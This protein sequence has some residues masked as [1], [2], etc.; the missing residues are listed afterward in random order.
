MNH[1]EHCAYQRGFSHVAGIDEAGRGP[2]AGPVVAAAVILPW[3]YSNEEIRDSKKLSEVKRAHLYQ[4]I[5][6][7]ALDVGIGV[8]EPAEIDRINILQA[9]ILAMKE[10]V[11]A[12]KLRADYLLID[13]RN[14]LPLPLEQQPIVKG[15]SLSISIAAASIIAKVS[16]DLIMDMYHRQY[17]QYN[18]QKNKGYPTAEHVEAL[19]RH[20]RCKIHRRSF[21]VR[22]A[23]LIACDLF[24]DEEA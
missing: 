24:T 13:G 7:D 2:L 10:A 9:T 18:F 11:L 4:V 6:N 5:R 8:V 12:L 17:P 21:K 23:G 19:K 1:F 3:N 14:Y 16:R 15:D 22:Q 20:G